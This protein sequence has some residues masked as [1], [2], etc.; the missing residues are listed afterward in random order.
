M[1]SLEPA[2]IGDHKAFKYIGGMNP[3][4]FIK[5]LATSRITGVARR[6]KALLVTLYSGHIWRINL[7]STGWWMPGNTQAQRAATVDPISLNFLH[8]VAEHTVRLK[9]TLDDGQIWD[10]HDSRTWGQWSLVNGNDPL[11]AKMGPDWLDA[12]LPAINVLL[13]LKPT[14]RKVLDIL[15]DQNITAGLGLYMTCEICYR[16]GIH[17]LRTW[18]SLTDED[19]EDLCT[20]IPNFIDLCM[21]SPDHGHW[22]VFKKKGLRCP[23]HPDTAISYTKVGN[24]ARGIYFCPKC[25]PLSTVPA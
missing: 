23:D 24:S 11:L 9:L 8:P 7:I 12:T 18:K 14:S 4:D 17:P 16:A 20:N 15:C 19:K 6:G 5:M 10:Y 25:Q 13:E 1:K 3:R 21:K 2:I 22:M